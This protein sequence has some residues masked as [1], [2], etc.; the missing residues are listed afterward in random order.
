MENPADR[1]DQLDRPM[2]VVARN[3][4][5]KR[6][7]KSAKC[8]RADRACDLAEIFGRGSLR[9]GGRADIRPIAF[10][11]APSAARSHPELSTFRQRLIAAGKPK[12]LA[13]VAVARKLVVIANA[14]IKQARTTEPELT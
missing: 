3:V 12:R 9:S 13:L 5:C 14:V 10:T 6:C 7:D 2:P 4:A 1:A 8:G 11:A